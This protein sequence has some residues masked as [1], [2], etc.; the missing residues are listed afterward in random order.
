[1]GA[2]DLEADVVGGPDDEVVRD[3]RP[4]AGQCEIAG[5]RQGERQPGDLVVQRVQAQALVRSS[6]S[7]GSHAVRM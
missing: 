6:C 1:M 2:V 3:H 7:R 5:G 4:A